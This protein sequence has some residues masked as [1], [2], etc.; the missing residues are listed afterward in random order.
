MTKLLIKELKIGVIIEGEVFLL[1]ECSLRETR[2]GSPHLRAILADRT[3]RI[4]ARY[5]DVAG[6]IICDLNI[7][8]GVQIDG[9]VEEYPLGSGQRHVRIEY[10]EP[11][12]ILNLEDFL[13]R[14]KRDLAEIQ[15]ELPEVCQS[16]ETPRYEPLRVGLCRFR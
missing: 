7:G 16:I 4:E 13:T 9:V 2:T 6:D 5:G 12:E 10:L 15:R 1:T 14:T 11:V 3:G 8:S